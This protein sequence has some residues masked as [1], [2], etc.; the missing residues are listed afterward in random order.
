MSSTDEQERD[1]YMP[2]EPVSPLEHI[3]RM[4]R[5]LSKGDECS[6]PTQSEQ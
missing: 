6:T 5:L 4:R 2:P 3:A 1:A